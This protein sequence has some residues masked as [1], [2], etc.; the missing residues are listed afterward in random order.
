[1]RTVSQATSSFKNIESTFRV[2]MRS[3]LGDDRRNR[4]C[5]GGSGK[6]DEA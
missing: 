6:C 5:L 3:I 2:F 1:M 4:P